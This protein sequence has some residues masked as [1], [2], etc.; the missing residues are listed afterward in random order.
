[1]KKNIHVLIFPAGE[2]NALELHDALS[3]CVNI[4]VFGASSIERHGRY[5]FERYIP[6]V[7]LITAPDFFEQFNALLAAHAI[8]VIFPTHDTVAEF[9]AAHAERIQA[10]II[11]A[12]P[13][14]AAVCRDKEKT[15]RLFADCD[16]TPRT[17]GDFSTLPVF[18][19]PRKGQGAVGTLL[20]ERPEDVPHPTPEEHVICEYL[21]GE[22]YTVDCLTDR[23]GA[24]RVVSPRSRRRVM[25]GVSVA[26]RTESLTEAIAA[27]ARTINERLTFL[28]LWWFQIKKD[29]EGNWKLL[30]ISTRCAGTMCLTRARGINLPLLSV[31][32]ALGR[33]ISVT[34][35]D[36]PVVMDRALV[37]RYEIGFVYDTVYLD[38]DDTLIVRGKVHLKAIWF[39][40]QCRNKGIDVVLLTRHEGDIFKDLQAYAIDP[41]LFRRIRHLGPR[42][43]KSDCIAPERAIFID[44]AYAEREAVRRA[45]TIPVF[46]VD[47]LEVLMDWKL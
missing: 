44:N 35:N 19:K 22:E 18:V 36:V 4:T 31:Y 9:F 42:E 6:G 16:F 47:A 29:R 21:P 27:I 7:P 10:R 2:I 30:E 26:G 28:G 3:T 34:P 24:L 17:Y 41:A 1:M 39:V 33:D 32:T 45:H 13:Q 46:D 40:Y 12:D 8:D 37:A 23:H 15:Y 43:R 14:T 11:V 25:A 20:V 38:F 5:V